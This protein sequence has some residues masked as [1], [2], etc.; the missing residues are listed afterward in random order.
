MQT[1]ECGSGKLRRASDELRE[2]PVMENTITAKVNDFVS[3]DPIV[4]TK[5]IMFTKTEYK[6]PPPHHCEHKM[7]YGDNSI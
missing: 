1:G 3:L 5:A 7:C 6:I 2:L 4:L